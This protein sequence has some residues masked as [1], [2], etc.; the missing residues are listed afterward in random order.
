MTQAQGFLGDFLEKR[1]I[2]GRI[3]RSVQ[4]C[5]CSGLTKI[6][7]KL[8]AKR[9]KAS[10]QIERFLLSVNNVSYIGNHM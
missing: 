4:G 6:H 3:P 7:Q 2:Q 5:T 10:T 1:G 9:A 8:T